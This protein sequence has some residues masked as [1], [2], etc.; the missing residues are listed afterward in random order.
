MCGVACFAG[1][2]GM[3]SPRCLRNGEC[4]LTHAAF[5][6]LTCGACP[7]SKIAVPF[8]P[9]PRQPR[10]S[11]VEADTKFT[12][13]AKRSTDVLKEA[14]DARTLALKLEPLECTKDR[15]RL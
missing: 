5:A 14:N 12:K 2:S 15:C 13:V 10:N 8:R 4:C 3:L 11:A 1:A 9:P 6:L 7:V